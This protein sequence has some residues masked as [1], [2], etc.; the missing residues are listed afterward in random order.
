[1]REWSLVLVSVVF[2]VLLNYDCKTH[3]TVQR[4][5]ERL[6]KTIINH[7][8]TI[9]IQIVASGFARWR[10]LLRQEIQNNINNDYGTPSAC[11]RG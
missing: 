10:R 9:Q 1:M 4:L 3:R 7:G 2:L 11:S 6:L 8:T 5:S